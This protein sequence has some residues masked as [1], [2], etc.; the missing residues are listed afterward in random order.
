MAKL[1][2][3]LF[4]PLR[5]AAAARGRHE[6]HLILGLAMY[7]AMQYPKNPNLP[8][9][10]TYFLSYLALVDAA[11]TM[12]IHPRAGKI[13]HFPL[14]VEAEAEK[15]SGEITHYRHSEVV[16]MVVR[17]LK[18]DMPMPSTYL[19]WGAQ[20]IAKAH[21][22][23]IRVS[24]GLSPMPDNGWNVQASVEPSPAGRD[25]PKLRIVK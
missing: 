16:P 13:R 17:W 15:V 6:A 4:I 20:L 14:T 3:K 24:K 25:K 5:E 21:I 7:A 9:G 2:P 19:A 1:T 10:D 12:D 11:G 8:L 23:A 22:D 18:P